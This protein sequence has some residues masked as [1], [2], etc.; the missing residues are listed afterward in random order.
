MPL[1]TYK[2]PTEELYTEVVQ[3][4]TDVH[5]YFDHNGLEW[6]RVFQSPQAAVDTFGSLDPFDRREFVKRTARKGMTVGDMWDES[7]KLSDKRASKVGK[8]YVKENTAAEYKKRTGKDHP[9]AEAIKTK[10]IKPS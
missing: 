6:L 8:D 7:K 9:H 3:R 10:F 4:M 1:Y 2:H 5:K